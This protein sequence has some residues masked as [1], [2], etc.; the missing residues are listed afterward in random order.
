MLSLILRW[1][2]NQTSKKDVMA[3]LAQV[4]NRQI[5]IASDLADIKKRVDV[6]ADMIEGMKK[7]PEGWHRKADKK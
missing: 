6:F 4:E 3:H 2:K 1:W 7:A 5:A